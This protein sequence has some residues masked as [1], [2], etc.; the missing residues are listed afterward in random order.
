MSMKQV[1]LFHSLLM[2]PTMIYIG[3]LSKKTLENKSNKLVD[4]AFYSV[5]LFALII[6][7]VVRNEFLKVKI[8]EWS[9]RNW[10]NFTHYAV[11]FGVFLYI[12]T[13]GRGISKLIQIEALII[14]I[15]QISIHIYYYLQKLKE[16][17]K[18]KK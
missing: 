14:G 10:I 18:E 15:L 12:G 17:K 11:F 9:K 1:N 16:E 5:V 4:G 13:R 6:P 7:F 2:G 3:L 8:K